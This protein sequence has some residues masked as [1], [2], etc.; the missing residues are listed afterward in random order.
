MTPTDLAHRYVDLHRGLGYTTELVNAL[1]DERCAVI[2]MSRA[3]ATRIKECIKDLRPDY[4]L[5]NIEFVTYA[6]NSGWRDKLL[7]R[8]MHVYFDN[9]VLDDIVVHH[10][11]SINQ[12][13]GKR[14]A[15]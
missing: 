6:P 5:D 2:T 7:F 11:S 9:D 4:N 10:V 8:E 3:N 1:P 14:L 15:A 12:V 13:Y